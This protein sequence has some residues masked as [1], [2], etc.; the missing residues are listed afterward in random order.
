MPYT[1]MLFKPKTSLEYKMEVSVK[2]YITAAVT[3]RVRKGFIKIQQ[4][5]DSTVLY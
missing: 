3:R 4:F 1:F 5:T 2:C